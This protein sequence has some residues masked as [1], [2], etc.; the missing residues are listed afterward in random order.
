MSLATK[1]VSFDRLRRYTQHV[2]SY[3]GQQILNAKG[4][5]A[6]QLN[7]KVDKVEGKGL[8]ANDFTTELKNKLNGIEA[9]AQVNTVTGIKG[10]A[11]STY[12]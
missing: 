4:E 7:L 11:E 6:K 9:G 1:F 8:S 3:V 2:K 12:R 5:W 10:N